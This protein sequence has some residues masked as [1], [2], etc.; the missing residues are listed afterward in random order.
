MEGGRA[1]SEQVAR[2]SGRAFVPLPGECGLLAAVRVMK[3]LRSRYDHYMLKL[4]DAMKPDPAYQERF[5]AATF[6]FSGG[7]Y[8]G[9]LH[10]SS[11]CT[12]DH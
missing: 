5:E 12:R 6:P 3:S 10:R 2:S 9:V 8:V 11:F 1:I 4:H 7:E